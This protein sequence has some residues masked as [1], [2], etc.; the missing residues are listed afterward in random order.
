MSNLSQMELQNLRHLIGSAT[1]ANAKLKDYAN[2]A[3]DPEVKD[4]FTQ[5]EQDTLNV[6]Q[7]LIAFLKD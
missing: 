4:I 5:R 7:Q 2:K 3:V 6:K 1:T